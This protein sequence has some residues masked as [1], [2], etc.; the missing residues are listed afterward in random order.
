MVRAGGGRDQEG[1]RSGE[2]YE[3]VSETLPCGAQL[4]AIAAGGGHGYGITGTY[5]LER[6]AQDA[7]Y[8]K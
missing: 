4:L 8:D 6:V 1:Q 7:S 3:A 2:G 5:A